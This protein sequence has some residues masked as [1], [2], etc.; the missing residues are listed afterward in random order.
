[1]RSRSRLAGKP[2]RWVML[3]VILPVWRGQESADVIGDDA[4]AR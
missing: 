4:R 1:M 2:C 3:G